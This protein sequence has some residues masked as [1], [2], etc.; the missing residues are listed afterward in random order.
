[1]SDVWLKNNTRA[2]WLGAA[3]PCFGAVVGGLLLGGAIEP[4]SD[5]WLRAMGGALAF[6]SLA[7]LCL[8]IWQ[9]QQPRLAADTGHLLVDLRV[10]QPI[11]VPLDVVEG[12]LL[13]QG[14]SFLPGKRFANTEAATL[15]VRLSERAPEWAM[16]ETDRRLGSWCGHYITIHGAWCE[17]LSVDL[18]NRLNSRLAEA[19]QA[20]QDKAG[21]R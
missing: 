9:A 16:I 12:F 18:V 15:I 5:V 8:I 13:G 6:L 7:F 14:P 2:A 21:A 3:P 17:A 4:L 10:G 20:L 11:R 1:M 19:K